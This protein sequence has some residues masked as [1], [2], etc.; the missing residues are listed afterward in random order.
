[1]RL[2]A[3]E[4]AQGPDA[5]R[6][7]KLLIQFAVE[8]HSFCM[9]NDTWRG[10]FVVIVLRGHYLSGAARSCGVRMACQASPWLPSSAF[11]NVNWRGVRAP[12][13]VISD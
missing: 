11:M 1:M 5:D 9:P 4:S 8:G 6:H 10:K 2:G 3:C 12:I 13:G 7:V